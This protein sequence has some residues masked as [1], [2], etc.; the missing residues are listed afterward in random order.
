MLDK[1]IDK[2]LNKIKEKYGP[3]SDLVTRIIKIKNQKIL[4]CFLE[5]VSSDDKISDFF[6]GYIDSY[7]KKQIKFKNLYE[8]LKNAIPNSNLS[9]VKN[10]ED[11]F[12]KLAS[13]FTCVFVDGCSEAISL[14]TRS[15]LDRG[16]SEN[17]VRGPKDSFTEN[18]QKN[19]G[20]IRKRIKD[21]NRWF[22]D[23][24]LGRRTKT[25]I[26]IAYIKDVSNLKLV[27]YIEEEL[28]KI[29]IDGI[30]DS[31]YIREFLLKDD[32]SFFP[33]FHSTERPD[34]ACMALLEGK[35]VILVENSPFVLLIPGLFIDFLHSPEDNYQKAI[36][37]DLTRIIRVI[38]FFI[39]VMFPGIYVAL[40]TFNPEIIPDELLISLAVQRGCVPFPT[41]LEITVM[42]ITFEILRESDVRIPNASG[43]A[44]GIVGALV[45]GEA[46]V[47]AGIVSPIVIIVIGL[48]SISGLLFTEIDFVN[49]I[50]WW[51]FIFLLAS[52]IMGVIGFVACL[53]LF[54]VKLCSLEF[55]GVSYLA[56]F[57]PYTKH[58]NAIFRK[59]ISKIK[60]RYS[61]LSKNIIRMRDDSEKN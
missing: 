30:L 1:N 25:K 44:I 6:M 14:E 55:Y 17:I 52:T 28:K 47:T 15:T 50:R 39:T 58:Q 54:I 33:R 59:P 57:S 41:A 34:L 35:I 40:T 8:S 21:P 51:R 48:T 31:G 5:S 13:G 38:S 45:L 56:P 9:T 16:V 4:Y 19:L 10:Y 11:V 32:K 20:L 36:N 12:Y 2:V 18:H 61:F 49:G 3:S 53:I 46:A 26:S 7:I 43:A 29:D 23:L 42:I 24:V 37:I 27:K 60:K 22:K